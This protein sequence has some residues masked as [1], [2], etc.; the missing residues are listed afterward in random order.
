VLE[1]ADVTAQVVDAL[2]S[3]GDPPRTLH[4]T[5]TR[6]RLEGIDTGW[7]V[8]ATRREGEPAP[9]PPAEAEPR[10]VSPG[11]AHVSP[12]ESQGQAPH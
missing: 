11:E 1:R 10:P 3:L 5:L 6:F 8:T 9:A 4:L 2:G 7:K 12:G